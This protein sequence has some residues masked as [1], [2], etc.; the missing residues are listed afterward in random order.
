MSGERSEMVS[1][2]AVTS[3]GREG[4]ASLTRFCTLTRAMSGSAPTLKVIVR[5]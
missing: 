3:V 2:M 4:S 5:R 1:P